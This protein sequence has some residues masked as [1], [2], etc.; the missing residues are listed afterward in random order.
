MLCLSFSCAHHHGGAGGGLVLQGSLGCRD[1]EMVEL[2]ISRVL[3]RAHSKLTALSFSR[4]DFC[5]SK[6]LLRRVENNG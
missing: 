1:H 6:D 3:G 4:S 2:E 5:L